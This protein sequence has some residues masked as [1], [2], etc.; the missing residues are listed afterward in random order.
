M[1][2]RSFCATMNSVIHMKRWLLMLLAAL[3]LTGCAPNQETQSPE[4]DLSLS[5]SL[6]EPL[7]Y[8]SYL[9]IDEGY[10]IYASAITQG[11]EYQYAVYELSAPFQEDPNSV[12]RG[13]R[14][15]GK[16]IYWQVLVLKYGEVVTVFREEDNPL[17][18]P[19][20]DV[21]TLVV[22]TDINFDGKN[23]ILLWQ[24]HFG[25]QGASHYSC[26]L[27]SENGFSRCNDF[28]YIP[29]P[30]LDRMSEVI[31]GCWRNS[32]ASHGWSLYRFE[33][34]D[35][36]ELAVLTHE[37]AEI[38]DSDHYIMGWQEELLI[39]GHWQTCDLHRTD[40]PDYDIR[41][42]QRLFGESSFW[43]LDSD[44]WETVYWMHHEPYD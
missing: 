42:A 33:D 21:D 7:K 16:S 9:E 17:A 2:G 1:T 30:N 10:S 8:L 19:I 34:G 11:E 36:K 14:Y 5:V 3:M 23:D 26:Y 40:D 41:S 39:D 32:A 22:E 38:I 27:A 12:F 25:V 28:S 13:P 43:H 6:A 29:N 44:R 24:G 20:P 18:G 31:M 37:P 15:D 35:L 4:I